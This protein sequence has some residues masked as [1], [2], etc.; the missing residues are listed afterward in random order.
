MPVLPFSARDHEQLRAIVA[1]TMDRFA[2]GE[3]PAAAAYALALGWQAGRR[4]GFDCPG[5]ALVHAE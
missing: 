4:E 5:Y 1:D 3:E 2:D